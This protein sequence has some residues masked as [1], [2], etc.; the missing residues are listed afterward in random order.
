[1]TQHEGLPAEVGIPLPDDAD[2]LAMAADLEERVAAHAP[3][4]E[5][6]VDEEQQA[7]DFAEWLDGWRSTI[8]E[9]K[10]AGPAVAEEYHRRAIAARKNPGKGREE[11]TQPADA[12]DEDQSPVTYWRRRRSDEQIALEELTP[13]VIVAGIVRNRPPIRTW[14]DALKPSVFWPRIT[15]DSVAESTRREDGGAIGW[16]IL[17]RQIDRGETSA[18]PAAKA[19]E[20]KPATTGHNLEGFDDDDDEVPATAD[21]H[22]EESKHDPSK[23]LEQIVLTADGRL[24]R[25][26]GPDT[27]KRDA[28]V[29]IA[30]VHPRKNISGP[31][32]GWRKTR[33]ENLL[34]GY[35]ERN[36][37][38]RT[39]RDRVP[40]VKSGEAQH[41]FTPPEVARVAGLISIK[42][43][44]SERGIDLGPVDQEL[45]ATEV[46]DALDAFRQKHGMPIPEYEDEP[47]TVAGTDAQ[48]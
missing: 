34:T 15:P 7:A 47:V 21:T 5:S 14:R 30:N 16:T 31:F 13:D 8:D 12:D 6:E 24:I 42:A 3:K 1:M 35:A 20:A 27:D 17:S 29:R 33:E 36:A 48:A 25:L 19:T 46:W 38:R 18:A 43:L 39:W 45:T 37:T 44:Q 10:D 40:F 41:N 22:E 26:V 11:I 28:T 2:R 23:D 32:A 4:P 9:A